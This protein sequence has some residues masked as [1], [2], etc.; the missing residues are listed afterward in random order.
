MPA[1]VLE[2]R[3]QR[4]LEARRVCDDFVESWEEEAVRR[5]GTPVVVEAPGSVKQHTDA[6]RVTDQAIALIDRLPAGKPFF[7]W[8][9]YMDPHGP[10]APPDRYRELFVGA[11]PSEPVPLDDLPSYQL[12]PDPITGVTSTDLGFY[13]TQYDREIRYVDDEIARLLAALDS[14]RL[15]EQTLVVVTADHGESLGEHGLY[16]TH[17]AL[18]EPTVRVPLMLHLPG[19]PAM[20]GRSSTIVENVDIAPTILDAVGLL[21][22][23]NFQGESLL[24][25]AARR[26]EAA[27][28]EHYNRLAT[29]FRRGSRKLI[30]SRLLKSRPEYE[31]SD[32]R[33]WYSAAGISVFDLKEDPDE[34]QNL[35]LANEAITDESLAF[36]GAW[37]GADVGRAT[38]F[39]PNVY[40]MK[41]ATVDRQLAESLRALGYL[42]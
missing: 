37:L 1:S 17:G 19:H 8:L 10:Y 28:F 14:R 27:F 39:D 18:Y 40:A 6:R 38:R 35:A 4:H 25:P 33:H 30:D 20:R 31:N 22:P 5:T 12:Q 36:L 32:V 21:S 23:S 9:H 11:H 3:S 29:G 34:Q 24:A 13:K 42:R 2:R 7:V 15:T 26:K 16:F 41:P